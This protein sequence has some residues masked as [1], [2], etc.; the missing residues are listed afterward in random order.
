VT[1]IPTLETERLWLRSWREGDLDRYY[2]LRGNETAAQFIGGALSRD[3]TWRGI[4]IILGHQVL[5]GY[6]IFALEEKAQGRLVGY[7]GPWFPLGFP[8]PE[9]GWGLLPSESGKGYATE[10]AKRALAFAFGP[11]GWTTAISLVDPKN[12]PSARVAE[13]LG[14]KLESSTEFRGKMCGVYRHTPP[15]ARSKSS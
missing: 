3:D 6:S 4:A 8:E 2:E 14:A 15:S 1:G 7:C 11:L 12:L 13:R 5:R 9:I 10:A